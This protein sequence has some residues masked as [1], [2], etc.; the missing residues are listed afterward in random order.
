MTPAARF[1]AVRRAIAGHGLSERRACRLLGVDRASFQYKRSGSDDAAVRAWL[2]ELASE[3]RRFGYRRLAILLRREGRAI[4]L[5]RVY[6]LHKEERLM[7]RKRGGRK[8][9]LGTRAPATIPQGPNQRWSLDFVSDALDDGCRFRVLNVVDDFSREC[10]ACVVD[11][12]LSETPPLA[13]STIDD[14]CEDNRRGSQTENRDGR[15]REIVSLDR[16]VGRRERHVTQAQPHQRDWSHQP[17]A[18]P[19]DERREQRADNENGP[20]EQG[21]SAE[22]GPERPAKFFGE[23]RCEDADRVEWDGRQTQRRAKQSADYQRQAVFELRDVHFPQRSGSFCTN[24]QLSNHVIGRATTLI[25]RCR[26]HVQ[27]SR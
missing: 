16:T 13:E 25:Y 22:D 15:P 23:D 24:G 6:R 8:R 12:S 14:P 20:G 21:Q 9:A 27:V 5:K 1:D 26:R 10:L 17:R 11:T 18:E 19:I 3:R 2:R 7:V 4:N